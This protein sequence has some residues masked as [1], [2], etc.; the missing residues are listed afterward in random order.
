LGLATSRPKILATSWLHLC[1]D[2][3][4]GFN[5]RDSFIDRDTAGLAA[6]AKAGYDGDAIIGVDELLY[7]SLPAASSA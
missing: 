7:S 6:P 2:G 5:M 1:S 3:L 4:E